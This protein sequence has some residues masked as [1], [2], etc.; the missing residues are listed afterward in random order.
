MKGKHKKEK[1]TEDEQTYEKSLDEFARL[2]AEGMDNE[3][4]GAIEPFEVYSERVKARIHADLDQFRN[5]FAKGYQAL[6][7]ELSHED[8][9][10]K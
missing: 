1:T 7:E 6:L 3:R 8:S 4:R 10:K 9:L 2:M 5:R